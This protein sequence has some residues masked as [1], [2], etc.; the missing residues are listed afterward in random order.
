MIAKDNQDLMGNE[1]SQHS[2]PCGSK[3]AACSRCAP[4][5]VNQSQSMRLLRQDGFGGLND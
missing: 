1:S 4:V 5:N 3:N 2:F